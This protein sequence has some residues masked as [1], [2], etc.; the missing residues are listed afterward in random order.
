MT[1][2][3]EFEV[4]VREV[5]RNLDK[6]AT[7]VDKEKVEEISKEGAEIMKEEI[8]QNVN[9]INEVT[10]RLKRAPVVRKL[11]GRSGLPAPYV[12]AMDRKKETGAP[13]AWLAEYYNPSRYGTQPYFRPAVDSKSD[14]V[15]RH[16][17]RGYKRLLNEIMRKT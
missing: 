1:D 4:D 5:E 14:D 7:L 13:H 11:S 6:L 2:E 9:R 10:G 15:E 16:M 12:A 3:V 8:Q 17:V